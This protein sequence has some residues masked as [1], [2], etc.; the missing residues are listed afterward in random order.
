MKNKEEEAA[1]GGAIPPEFHYLEI[2]K[3]LRRPEGDRRVQEQ[4]HH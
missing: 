1:S 4:N 3:V 2:R